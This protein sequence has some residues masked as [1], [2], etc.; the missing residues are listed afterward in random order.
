MFALI[1]II[2]IMFI[3]FI[4]GKISDLV[5]LGRDQYPLAETGISIRD[6]VPS[7]FLLIEGMMIVAVIGLFAAMYFISVRSALHTHEEYVVTHNNLPRGMAEIRGIGGRAFPIAA[8]APTVVMLTFF[9]VVPL[10][11]SASVAFTDYSRVN[12]NHTPQNPISW[13]GMDNFAS[14]FG[15]DVMWAGALGRVAMWTVSWALLATVTCYFGGTVLAV[16]LNDSGF[17]SVTRF[18]AIFILPYAVPAVISML[19]WQNIL[20]G[21]F[22][23][24]N[25]TLIEIGLINSGIP[26]LTDVW[27][28]RF[29]VVMINLWAG[30]PYF[31]LLVT[32]TMTAI[33]SDIYEAA[34]I[35]G[36]NKFQVFRRITLPIV[37][38]QT[39]PLIIMS[40]THNINNFGAI[41]FLSGG[42]PTM[43]D[44]AL[45]NAGGTDILVT[46]IF[47]LVVDQQRYNLASVL[48][49]LI[50]VTLAPFAIWNFRRTKSFKEGEI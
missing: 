34:Q 48:A 10:L 39:T 38:Y 7:Y 26:W 6:A 33:P 20:N 2:F 45:T 27:L 4:A 22:G 13:V 23:T 3:P 32:G 40:F 43:P 47:K 24:L 18:R 16:V 44:S 41:F 12:I 9:V 31:M 50:F 11:F 29:T 19:V 17:K 28:T 30:F 1:E 5:T 36:A 49:V 25:R 14:M 42:A 37:L 8:L 46:W 21:S 15:G 35:D